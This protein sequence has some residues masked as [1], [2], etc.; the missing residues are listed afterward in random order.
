MR[1]V[2]ITGGSR[3]IGKA[4]AERFKKAGYEVTCP[5]RQEMDLSDPGS[6][7]R[8]IEANKDTVFDVIVNNAGINDINGIED[9]T[10]SEIDSMMQVNLMSPIR[11]LRG[12]AANMKKQKYGRIVNIGSVWAV[13]SKPGRCIYSATKNGIH[14]VTNTLA[15]ELAPDNILVNTVCPGFT[16]TE[17]TYKN[18]TPEQIE[19]ISADI[20]MQRMAQPDEI[21]ELIYFLGSEANTYIIGQKITIDGGYTSK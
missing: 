2:L 8:Y 19:S 15:V 5:T 17:L 14:G 16:L 13:V 20:P 21:A 4:V 10:D 3:G 12:F 9:I 6:V 11:I 18:N 1:K 7:E